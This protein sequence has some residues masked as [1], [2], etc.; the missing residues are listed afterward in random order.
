M[1]FGTWGGLGPEGSRTLHRLVK[2]AASWQEGELR[3]VRQQELMETVGLSL[4]R[5]IWRL[6]GKKNHLLR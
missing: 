1:A 5:Q 3:A 6:L 2:R 4:M